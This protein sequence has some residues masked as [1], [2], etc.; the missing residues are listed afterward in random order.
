MM[1]DDAILIIDDN[2]LNL[3][4]VSFLLTT[5]GHLIQTSTNAEE[6]L[7]K[8]ESFKPSLI[9]MDIQ[10]PG[11]DGL[12]LTKLIKSRPEY[13][14]IPIIALTAYAMK[15]DKERILEAGCDG[16]IAKPIDTRSF[17]DLIKQYLQDANKSRNKG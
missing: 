14:N 12:A 2:I 1:A 11:M 3:K 9:L 13:K 5:N 4:L 8:L 10:L 6:A 17:P 7:K 16:Y 15:G